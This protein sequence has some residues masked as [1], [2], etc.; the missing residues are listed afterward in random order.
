MAP[1]DQHDVILFAPPFYRLAGRHEADYQSARLW[2]RCI[3][4]ASPDTAVLIQVDDVRL[5]P[6]L[7]EKHVRW[8]REGMPHVVSGAKFEGPEETWDLSAC[9]RQSLSGADGEARVGV[10]ATAMW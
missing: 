7:V 6:D 1:M 9:R 4:A 3:A 10:P 2:N 8:H 5:R